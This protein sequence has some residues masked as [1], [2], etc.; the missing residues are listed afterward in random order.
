MIVFTTALE[1]TQYIDNQNLILKKIG[2]VPTMGALH[3]GHISLVNESKKDNDIT[4]VSIFVNP[5]QFNNPE[6][7]A[8]YPNTIVADKAKL[9]EASCEILFLPDVAEMYPLGTN[10]LRHYDIDELDTHL[11]GEFR[12]GHFQGV[13]NVVHQLLLQTNP[14]YIYMGAKDYQQC[15]VVKKLIEVEKLPVQLHVCPTLREV[16][17]LAM[18]SRNMRLSVEGKQTASIIYA[19]LL[20]LKNNQKD[21]ILQKTICE[22]WLL[23][24]GFTLEYII[25]AHATDL[26]VL[27]DFDKAQPMVVLFAAWLEG[28]RLIDNMVI[29]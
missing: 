6:D 21:F 17:G 3:K 20:H 2:F 12:P 11:E 1:L 7:F 8:K 15:M 10:H 14:H 25:L 13:C 23:N 27:S 24:A 9:I 19:S 29:N 18:S 28:V 5:T 16:S 26:K 4:I 22:Q